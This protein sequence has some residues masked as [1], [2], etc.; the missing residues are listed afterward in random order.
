MLI[1]KLFTKYFFKC[2]FINYIYILMTFLVIQIVINKFSST[3]ITIK[4]TQVD[5][6][7]VK[8]T[9][10]VFWDFSLNWDPRLNDIS[11]HNIFYLRQE[12]FEIL[13]I[14]MLDIV[15]KT[16]AVDTFSKKE[17]NKS[18]YFCNSIFFTD[19]SYR[20]ILCT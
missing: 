11:N 16:K 18:N 17:E 19:T 15:V 14:I 9:T 10:K 5:R 8:K 13:L 1:D 3:F 6:R 2:I 12:E 4:H 7:S 20:C